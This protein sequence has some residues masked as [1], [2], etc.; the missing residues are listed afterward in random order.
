MDGLRNK[1][2]IFDKLENKLDMQ[3]VDDFVVCQGDP[4]KHMGSHID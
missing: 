2:N 1:N 3:V 4:S